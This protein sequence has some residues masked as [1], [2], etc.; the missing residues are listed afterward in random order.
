MTATSS[1][2][3]SI[4]FE[5]RSEADLRKA[6][7]HRYFE[8][9]S[10]EILCM[11][12]R[13]GDGPVH[14]WRAGQPDPV[15]LIEHVHARRLVVAHNNAFDRTCWNKLRPDWP[16]LLLEQC[17]CT[18]ARGAAMAL[19]QSLDELG[20][21]LKAPLRKDAAGHRLMMRM[22][23]P[24]FIDDEDK[25]AALADYCVQDVEAERSIDRLVPLLPKTE[26]RIWLLDQTINDRGVAVDVAL[27]HKAHAAVQVAAEAAHK[28]MRHLTNGSVKKTSEVAKIVAWL[29]ARGIPCETIAKG[30]IDELILR[31]GLHDD[32]VA[33]EVL[34]LRREA[35]KASTAKYQA[36][37]NSVC[38]DGRVRGSLRYHGAS[39][40]R[41]AGSGM[42]PQNFPRVRDAAAVNETLAQLN[43]G[44]APDNLAALSQCLRAMIVAAPGHRLIGGDYANIEGRVNAWLAGE[45]WKVKAFADYDEGI[46]D[47]LYSLAYARAFGVEVADVTNDQRQIGK[48]MELSMGFQGGWRAFEKMGANYGITVGEERGEILKRLWRDAHPAITQSW[49]ELQ[50][51]ALEAVGAPGLSIPALR[52]RVHYKVAH[53]MLWCQL[54]SGRA[55]V[56]AAPRIQWSEETEERP[57]RPQVIFAGVD[58]TTKKWGPHALYGGLQCE[59]I[60]QAVARDILA[61][62]MLKVEAAGYPLV[63]TVHDENIAEVPNHIGSV[64]EFAALMESLPTW[65]QGLPVAVK[66]WEDKRYVK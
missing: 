2:V 21:A 28:Q 10:T 34:C 39:T 3:A 50:D 46:G 15:K 61:H 27:V 65:A 23:R 51:A 5:T 49:W 53:G 32:P 44:F 40:G 47:D 33:A 19:P 6:G 37:I 13:I 1:P 12:W 26:R 35:A 56:Y 38:K 7:L 22:C 66:A 45:A 14:S 4:D 62:G 55:L 57:S 64:D 25:L 9:E 20:K 63:L 48:V 60:V 11:A 52:G 54:P 24:P 41:W 8:D 31:A 17:D 36:I 18:M 58:S 59:N 29:A 43:L 16:P 42:Q 30:E